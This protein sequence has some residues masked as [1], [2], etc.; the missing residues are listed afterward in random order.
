MKVN[1][2]VTVAKVKRA[3]KELGCLARGDSLSVDV[4]TT[5]DVCGV[6]VRHQRVI[7]IY[8]EPAGLVRVFDDGGRINGVPIIP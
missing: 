3:R 7:N 8:F 1:S 5:M 6:T 4:D 2:K